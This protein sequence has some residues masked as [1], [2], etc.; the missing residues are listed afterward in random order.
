MQKKPQHPPQLCYHFLLHITFYTSFSQDKLLRIESV[1]FMFKF[2][3]IDLKYL[4]SYKAQEL[5]I[6]ATLELSTLGLSLWKMP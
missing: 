3:V 6:T 2:I 5:Y 4:K 1:I